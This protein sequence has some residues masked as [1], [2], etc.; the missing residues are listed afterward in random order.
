MEKA[1][2]RR[3]FIEATSLSATSVISASTI[4]VF[5]FSTNQSGK[6]AIL[7][8]KPVR[9]KPFHPWPVWDELDEKAIIPVLRSGVWS[10]NNVVSEAEEKFARLMGA[11]HCL[12]TSNGTNALFTAL[13]AL[14]VGGGDEV[15]TTPYTFVATI[16]AIL[17]NNAL[18]VFVDIDPETWQI[19]PE[20][21]EEKITENTTA[22]LPVHITCGMSHMD[23][24]NAIAKKHNLKVIEDACQAHMAEWNN[25][26]AGTLGDLGCI[27]LQNSKSITCG[28]GGAILGDDE[29][30]MDICYSFHNFGRPR[31]KYMTREHGG[32]PILGTKCRMAEYQ[33]S[34]LITQMTSVE[35]ETKI[36]S[37]NASYLT[38]KL[39]EIPGLVPLKHYKEI[40]R[41]TFYHYG[42]RY[43][44]EHFNN[45][46]R[47][48]F[49]EA[50][51]AEG[52]PIGSGLGVIEGEPMHREGLIEATLNSKTF[53]NL[54]S[55]EQLDS[56]RENLDC[57]ECDQLVQETVGF[58]NHVLLGTK[59]D[60]DDIFNAFLKVYENR[61]QL[62]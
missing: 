41:P 34:I 8:G 13:R 5:G 26:K 48:K 10:R 9:T 23:K 14:G 3:R 22:I 28:E 40:T 6:L 57:P 38:A 29:Q 49:I 25:K 33:A 11:K 21:I 2:T 37:A 16:D 17:L 61:E 15:I 44:K 39:K 55:N 27:S 45:C 18:P 51:D 47:G 58:H 12:L 4:P 56:Y 42:I 24:I 52:I 50:L 35:E 53:S 30:I 43:K 32:H 31:G 20:K 1:I 36:R 59:Q 62:I 19:D 54:Y 46:P 7:G 60:M